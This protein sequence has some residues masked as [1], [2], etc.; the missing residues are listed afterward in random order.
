MGTRTN[1]VFHTIWFMSPAEA[2]VFRSQDGGETFRRLGLTPEQLGPYATNVTV[3]PSASSTIYVNTFNG[4]FK[5]VNGGRTFTAINNG[6]RAA[7]IRAIAFDHR[8]DPNLYL[9]TDHGIMRTRTRGHHYER[10]PG[11]RAL[12]DT[13]LLAIAP[14]DPNMILAATRAGALYRTLDGGQSWTQS[15]VATPVLTWSMSSTRDTPTMSITSVRRSISSRG[16]P[17]KPGSI[18]P[19]MPERRSRGS[20]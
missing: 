13:R 5:S 7:I 15:S 18:D 3:D 19:S 20:D 14:S 12:N 1:S 11:P 6:W 10:V 16:S 8:N 17:R 4:N 9:A 2:G